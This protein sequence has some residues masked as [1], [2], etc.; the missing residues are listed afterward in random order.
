MECS[1]EQINLSTGLQQQLDAYHHF[2]DFSHCADLTVGLHIE[3]IKKILIVNSCP[4]TSD[5]VTSDQC[6]VKRTLSSYVPVES[7]G[8]LFA[9]MFCAA[10]HGVLFHWLQPVAYHGFECSTTDILSVEKHLLPFVRNIECIE[11]ILKIKPAF[12]NLQR[13]GDACSCSEYLPYRRCE[14]EPY[15]RECHAYSYVVVDDVSGRP[16]HNEACRQC[17]D[18]GTMLN[19]KPP[20]CRGTVIRN[21]RPFV[22][23]FDFTGITSAPEPA[24]CRTF[25]DK[26][27]SGNPCLVMRCQDGF[28]VHYNRCMPMATAAACFPHQQNH[29]HPDS[30]IANLFQS[31]MILHYRQKHPG[32][33]TTLVG[34]NAAIL[35]RGIPC[36]KLPYLHHLD[37]PHDVR[38]GMRC[39]VINFDSFA[40]AKL[41]NELTSKDIAAKLFPTLEVHYTALLNHD[42]VEGVTCSKGVRLEPMTHLEVVKSGIVTVRSRETKQ[43]FISNKH[44]LIVLRKTNESTVEIRAVLCRINVD[45]LNCSEKMR[46]DAMQPPINVCLK[47]MLTDKNTTIGNVRVLMSGKQL[48]PGDFLV[49]SSG[50]ILM[51]V[52]LYKKLHGFKTNDSKL[53]I[54]VPVVYTVSLCCL[55]ATFVIYMRY[56]ALRTLPGLM[57]MNLI[58]ALFFAQLLFLLDTLG[59]F[60]SESVFCQ[61]MASAQHYFWLASFAW[62]ACMSLDIFHCLN[63]MSTPVNTFTPSK[64]LKYVIT[65]W[66]LPL[67]IPLIT[68]VLTSTP[69]STLGYTTSGPCWLADSRSVLYLFAIPVFTIVCA[70]VILFIGSVCRLCTMVKNASFVGRKKD[71]KQRLVQCIKLSSWMGIS[72]LFG[73]AP[74]YVNMEALWFVFATVNAMQGVHIFISFG[75]TGKARVLVHGGSRGH[76]DTPRDL[77]ALPTAMANLPVY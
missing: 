62:M 27:E 24:E 70:N 4:D 1:N 73:I 15:Q 28:E 22:K 38:P 43:R 74:N 67:L 36:H 77:T 42:P 44:P 13:Y 26:G 69:S 25:Y 23:L 3:G 66:L 29:H 56:P 45:N 12:N 40:F 68:N 51:C 31:A 53:F 55:M 50:D 39:V 47:Y 46:Q 60:P 64:Y 75:I 2:A 32:A 8:V 14:D 18:N 17:D 19:Y 11:H 61:V 9:N 49:S 71:N 10:C 33:K 52:D 34:A 5:D 65:G 35:K 16:Y 57:L 72:W 76:T 30:R 37:W 54:V 63:R 20:W 7:Q 48:N 41:T 58:L 21:D 6:T 59:I